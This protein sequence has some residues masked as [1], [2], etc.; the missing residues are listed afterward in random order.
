MKYKKQFSIIF[1]NF[2]IRERKNLKFL[3][4]FNTTFKDI[5]MKDNAIKK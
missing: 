4:S 1:L 5:T 3:N 2:L